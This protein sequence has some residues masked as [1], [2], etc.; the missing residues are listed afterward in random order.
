MIAI[1]WRAFVI[2]QCLHHVHGDHGNHYCWPPWT[3]RDRRETAQGNGVAIV[4]NRA[5][6]GRRDIFLNCPKMYHSSHG[7]DEKPIVCRSKTG[8]THQNV[9]GRNGP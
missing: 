7:A 1:A 6:R 3:K 2:I 4:T 9:T 5:C 8:G